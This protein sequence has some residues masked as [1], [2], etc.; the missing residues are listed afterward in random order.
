MLEAKG[1]ARA[2]ALVKGFRSRLYTRQ[3]SAFMA[4][5]ERF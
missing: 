2:F 1:L 5:L 4:I 3:R